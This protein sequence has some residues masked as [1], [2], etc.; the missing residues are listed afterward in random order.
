VGYLGYEMIRFFEPSVPVKPNPDLPD[1]IFLLTD[2]TVA[3]DH[4]FG[5]LLLIANVYPNG[6][7]AA[8]R[9]EA[10]ARLDEIERRLASPLPEI[11]RSGP[12]PASAELYSNVTPE[13]F[14]E[15][16]RAAKEHIAAGDIFQ[17]VLSQR[18]SRETTASPFAIYRALR[19][20]N[21]SP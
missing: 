19:R 13:Q 21:P 14:M 10:E 9:A 5:R 11:P 6:D 1:G 3:F 17:V 4:A 15:S 12:P 2:T 8:A 18:L 16:V 7:E 20:L